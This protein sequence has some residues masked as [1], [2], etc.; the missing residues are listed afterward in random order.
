VSRRQPHQRRRWG[1]TEEDR[2]RALQRARE[3]ARR[4]A[5]AF[6]LGADTYTFG[7]IER[8]GI[9]AVRQQLAA[10]EEAYRAEGQRKER[11]HVRRTFADALR[12]ARRDDAPAFRIVLYLDADAKRRVRAER[13][14][15][16][17][18]ILADYE[19]NGGG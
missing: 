18:G 5:E 10:N 11:E 17:L 13:D 9:P 16:A 4:A 19:Q 15:A 8:F 3:E 1:Q 2:E 7:L 12:L 14:L 6:L